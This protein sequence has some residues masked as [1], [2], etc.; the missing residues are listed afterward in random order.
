MYFASPLFL[1]GLLAVSIPIAVHLFKFRR[2]RKEYFSNT[3][4]LQQ[5]SVEH[6]KQSQLRELLI[7]AARI[8][9]IACLVIAFSQPYSG[10]SGS[11]ADGG[12]KASIYVDNSYSMEYIGQDES[13]LEKARQDARQII[14]SFPD[15]AQLQILTNSFAG[16]MQALRPKKEI[17]SLLPD[18][19]AVPFP[20]SFE[21]INTRM[22]EVKSNLCFYISDFQRSTFNIPSDFV[23]D[24]L[25]KRIFISLTPA[26][27]GQSNNISIDSIWTETPLVMPLKDVVVKAVLTNYGRQD[28]DKVSL[29]MFIDGKQSSVTAVDIP[30]GKSV[31]T[32]LSLRFAESGFKQGYLEISDYP[33]EYDNRFYFTF[34]VSASLPVLHIFGERANTGIEKIFKGDSLFAYKQLPLTRIDYSTVPNARL[35]IIDEVGSLPEV[36]VS[37]LKAAL[38]NGASVVIVPAVSAAGSASD[39]GI[40]PLINSNYG[41]FKTEEIKVTSVNFEHPLFKMAFEGSAVDNSPL[42]TVKGR[43][44]LPQNVPVS[45]EALMSFT[46]SEDFMRVYEMYNG[47][48]Y[49]L[50]SP[51]SKDYTSFTSEYSFV[52]SF[53]NMAL[54]SKNSSQLYSVAGSNRGVRLMLQEDAADAV[55]GDTPFALTDEKGEFSIIPQL[56]NINN[57]MLLFTGGADVKAGNYLLKKGAEVVSALSFNDNRKESIQDYYSASELE[58]Y[59]LVLNPDKVS[60]SDALYRA[61]SGRPLWKYFLIL[62]LVFIAAEVFLLRWESVFGR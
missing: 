17:L 41:K 59:G 2:Y 47:F 34:S 20:R 25:V 51:I 10:F 62:A 9:A 23:V 50:S 43:Y 33:V 19:E 28:R 39:G 61:Y 35:V 54:Y 38:E 11:V 55:S 16:N 58:K 60:V 57:E 6:K 48:L 52:V 32:S 37:S 53:L 36:L 29:R 40:I 7:L 44:T 13:L 21:E 3:R 5:I 22:E 14:S 8:L 31:E 18:I 49:L 56:R 12:V 30:A 46:G 24:T 42:P 15:D 1:L 4:F 45:S 27:V 26:Q